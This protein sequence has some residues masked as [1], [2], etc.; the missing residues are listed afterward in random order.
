[1]VKEIYADGAVGNFNLMMRQER[2]T[3]TR[4]K[5]RILMEENL[6]KAKTLLLRDGYVAPM[7]FIFIGKEIGVCPLRFK[8]E[9]EKAKQLFAFKKFA[10]IKNADA[11]FV[12]IESWY[13]TTDKIDKS[14]IP[15][16]HPDRKECI[17]AIGEGKEGAITIIQTFGRKKK[18]IIFEDK[19]EMKGMESAIFNFGIKE[20]HDIAYG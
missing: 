17:F 20:E 12:I 15:S 7:G 9:K 5:L 13:V 6:E 8:D 10:K 3:V 1:M 18:K 4:D 11:V 14:I 16:K 2:M 19:M